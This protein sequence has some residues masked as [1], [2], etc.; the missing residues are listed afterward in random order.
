MIEKLEHIQPNLKISENVAV[1]GSSYTLLNNQYGEE[2][3]SCFY[4]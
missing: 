3:D 4:W 2:I 1:I